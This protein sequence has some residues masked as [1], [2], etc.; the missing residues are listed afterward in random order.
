M[1]LFN[2]LLNNPF[3][4]RI[5]M[6]RILGVK[7]QMFSDRLRT[8]YS[9]RFKMSVGKYSYGCFTK[10]FNLS[11]GGRVDIGRYC[12]FAQGVHFFGANH[13]Y[14]RFSTSPA[15][16]RPIFGFPVKDTRRFDLEIGDD[17]WVG[18]GAYIM[19]GC[20]KIGNGSVIAAGAVAFYE[21]ECPVNI[22]C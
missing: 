7:G 3:F 6:N 13:P 22:T 14:E 21:F 11:N 19:S 9:Q 17:V 15:F 1:V 20:H 16:Y 18:Y 4:E 10:D 12:S 2:K 8:Y 5:Y